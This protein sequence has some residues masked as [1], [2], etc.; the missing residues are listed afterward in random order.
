M[1]IELLNSKELAQRMGKKP[2]YVTAMCASTE[3]GG[4]GYVFEYGNQTTFRHAMAWRAKHSEF[5]ST[6]YYR[7]ARTGKGRDWKRRITSSAA[8]RPLPAD[9]PA[10]AAGKSGELAHS[11]GQ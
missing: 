7:K 3:K 4:G 6:D 1:K 10:D 11:N 9:G 8:H 5:S 2:G